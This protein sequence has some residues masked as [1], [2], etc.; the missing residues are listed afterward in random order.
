MTHDIHFWLGK[1][2]THDEAGIAA[3]KTVE[4]DDGLGGSPVQHREVQGSESEL[5]L[6]YFKSGGGVRY[7]SGGIESGFNHVKPTEYKSKLLHVKGKRNVRVVEIEAKTSSMNEGDVYIYDAG[8]NLYVYEGKESSLAEKTKAIQVVTQIK[9]ERSKAKANV[10]KISDDPDNAAFWKAVGPKSAIKSAKEGGSDE[11]SEKKSAPKLYKVSDASGKLTTEEVPLVDGKMKKEMLDSM[12]VFIV[13]A[14]S[15]IFV[16]V[17]KGASADEKKNAMITGVKYLESSKKPSSTPVERVLEQAESVAFTNCFSGWKPMLLASAP[18]SSGAVSPR[19]SHRPTSSIDMKEVLKKKEDS[20][21]LLDDGSGKLQ[22]W[23]IEDMEKADVPKDLYGQFYGGDSYIIQYSYKQNGKDAYMV[24]FWL[25]RESSKD[26]VGAAAIL[27]TK[28]RD[29]LPGA[30][31]PICR[32]TQGKEPQHFCILFKGGLV[33]HAGGRASGFKNRAD[34]D[35]YDTDGVSLFHVKGTNANNTKAVQV[36]EKAAALNSGDCFV[37][38]TPGVMFLWEGKKSSAAEKTAAGKISALLQG[39]RTITK[40]EEG[41][42]TDA[43]WKPLGGKGDYN[44]GIDNGVADAEPRLFQASNGKSGFYVEEITNFS[45]EDL[46]DEDVMLLDTYSSLFVWV[47]SCSNKEEQQQAVEFAERYIKEVDDGRDSDCPILRVCAGFE[48][49][50][51]TQHFVGWN[52]ALG[53]SSNEAYLRKLKELGS[54]FGSTAVEKIDSSAFA[55]KSGVTFAYA[56]LKGKGNVPEG[57][58]PANKEKYL[59]AEEF[60]TVFGMDASEFAKQPAWKVKQ[61]KQSKD[62]F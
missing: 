51:F 36:E 56:A 21:K 39:K 15:N 20:E 1:G 22:I 55:F 58:D 35:S 4:L 23:R 10:I 5:F 50:L 52:P 57:C 33:I 17:G 19:G 14:T 40:V 43:F 18:S 12:D 24:Y 34:A 27:A 41:K 11:E 46:N 6:S 42:E 25:G 48:P 29:S 53:C 59:S 49:I 44:T 60:K 32:V 26:E 54:A 31:A 30:N 38:Q 9:N 2:T 13:D 61:M 37:L 62:L 45:Q 47:G 8:V 7:A 3:Y 16:W 28:V